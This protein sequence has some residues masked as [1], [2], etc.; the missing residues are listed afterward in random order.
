MEIKLAVFDVDG[1]LVTSGS[2]IL[3]DST[4]KSILELKQNGFKVAIASGRPLYAL[5]KSIL[6]QIHFDYFVCSNGS[7]VYDNNAKKMINKIELTDGLIMRYKDLSEK[8]GAGFLL[9]FEKEGYVYAGYAYLAPMLNHALGRLDIVNHQ[10]DQSYH[11]TEPPYSI[12]SYI[13]WEKIDDFKQEFLE[14]QFTSFRENFYDAYLDGISKASGIEAI[15]KE[16][17]ITMDQV[18]SFGDHNNDFEMI[19]ESGI[20]VA[21]GNAIDSIKEIADYVTADT[22]HDGIQKALIEYGLIDKV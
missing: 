8:L 4:V 21:M 14:L 5:E 18:I 17:S 11:L 10:N 19:K 2:R 13:P 7:L 12:V 15:T 22:N 6:D 1:T 3:L 9:Q 20:G 16:L